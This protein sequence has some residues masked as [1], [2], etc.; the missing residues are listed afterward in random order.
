MGIDSRRIDYTARKRRAE[1]E[2][3]RKSGYRSLEEGIEG[4]S[5]IRSLDPRLPLEIRPEPN[6]GWSRSSLARELQFVSA[7]AVHH[8]ALIRLSLAKRGIE[9][10][11]EFG[12]AASTR[13][14]LAENGSRD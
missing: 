1:T 7:H 2:E 5:R 10:P 12:V 6:Q 14:H 3:S 11:A 13:A 8:F 9:F 4:L